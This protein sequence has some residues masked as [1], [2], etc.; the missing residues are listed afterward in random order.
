MDLCPASLNDLALALA[1]DPCFLFPTFTLR[2]YQVYQLI[3]YLPC[4]ICVDALFL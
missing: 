2:A 1:E 3:T 4:I